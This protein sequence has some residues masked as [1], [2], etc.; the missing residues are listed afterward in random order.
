MSSVTLLYPPYSL[1]DYSLSGFALILNFLDPSQLYSRFGIILRAI[2]PLAIA[3]SCH[4]REDKLFYPK[5]RTTGLQSRMSGD[6]T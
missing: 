6:F 2:F 1:K 5:I 4:Q 3:R